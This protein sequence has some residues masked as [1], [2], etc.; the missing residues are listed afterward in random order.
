MLT[1]S[2]GVIANA[3]LCRWSFSSPLVFFA[4]AKP[5]AIGVC[6]LKLVILQ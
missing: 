6:A 4:N 5:N 3:Q 2:S 1:F